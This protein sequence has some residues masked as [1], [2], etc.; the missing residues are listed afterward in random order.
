MVVAIIGAASKEKAILEMLYWQKVELSESGSF[1]STTYV[2]IIG[3]CIVVTIDTTGWSASNVDPSGTICIDR[4]DADG[5]GDEWIVVLA[6]AALGLASALAMLA[7]SVMKLLSSSS[8]VAKADIGC[9]ILTFVSTAATFGYY[10]AE[11]H[12]GDNLDVGELI[13]IGPAMVLAALGL[14]LIAIVVS[15]LHL[16]RGDEG[17][18]MG[19]PASITVQ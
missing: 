2:G 11:G 4:T 9:C 7:T 17:K 8:K 5:D 13:G 10:Y 18:V 6:L 16:K 14:S 15:A 3:F 19:A 1:S 12:V